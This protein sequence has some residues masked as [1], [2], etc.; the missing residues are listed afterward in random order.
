MRK[1]IDGPVRVAAGQNGVAKT[2]L[3]WY[4]SS[5]FFNL[6]KPIIYPEGRYLS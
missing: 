3:L 2:P 5:P 6:Q 1:N 4:I